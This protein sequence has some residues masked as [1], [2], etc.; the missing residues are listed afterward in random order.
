MRVA[1]SLLALRIQLAGPALRPFL[2]Q[3]QKN[4]VLIS[5]LRTSNERKEDENVFEC[6][7]TLGQKS[8]SIEPRILF[9]TTLLVSC[10]DTCFATVFFGYT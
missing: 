3:K 10:F 5:W 4:L 8:D 6:F 9:S 7:C 2:D 1:V